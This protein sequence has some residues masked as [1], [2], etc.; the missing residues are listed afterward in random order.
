VRNNRFVRQLNDISRTLQA[1]GLYHVLQTGV[2]DGLVHVDV[3]LPDYKIALFLEGAA[4]GSPGLQGKDSSGGQRLTFLDPEGST[5]TGYDKGC[6]PTHFRLTQQDPV[7][8]PLDDCRLL[9]VL[10]GASPR[11]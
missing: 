6:A 8:S 11:L 7:F 3:A 1:M 5:L 2:E 4:Q 10:A 9:V